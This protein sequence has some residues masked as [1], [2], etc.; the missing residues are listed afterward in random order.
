MGNDFIQR[1]TDDLRA[2]HNQG[3]GAADLG[4]LAKEALGPAFSPVSF[5]G[6][7]RSA[8][9]IPLDVLQRAL[10]WQGFNFGG[11]V[12]SDEEF[13]DLLAEWINDPGGK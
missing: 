3:L 12:I 2:A 11:S 13:T 9:G 10:A 4:R 6:V 8:F 7:F 5:V 1:A